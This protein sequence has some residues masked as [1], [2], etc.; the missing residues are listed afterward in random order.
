MALQDIQKNRKIIKLYHGTPIKNITKFDLSKS[1][2]ILDF[3]KGIYFTTN[4]KQ[5]MLWAIKKSKYG[6]V[7]EVLID[8]S[9]LNIK[10]FLTYSN[11]FIETFCYCR[12]GMEEYTSISEYEA[13]YGYVVDNNKQSIVKYTNDFVTGKASHAAVRNNITVIDSM[14]QICIKSQEV[15]D[16]IKIHRASEV[17][18]I[19]GYNKNSLEA[20]KWRK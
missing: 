4:E 14:D 19:E 9:Q 12:A 18:W 6:V 7:Y 11:E 1:R 15:L 3:G 10:Q 16:N 8:I 20:V 13:V 2:N 17:E 5:A